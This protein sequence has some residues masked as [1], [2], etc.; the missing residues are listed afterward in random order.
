VLLHLL[1][2]LKEVQVDADTLEKT[3]GSTNI[4]KNGLHEEKR[5]E[6]LAF[7]MCSTE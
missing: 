1:G 7:S 5:A 2:R 4:I 3:F 6:E